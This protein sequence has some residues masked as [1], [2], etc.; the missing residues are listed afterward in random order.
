MDLGDVQH[1]Y[2]KR[3]D[4]NHA[5]AVR[6]LNVK[7]SNM[8]RVHAEKKA[9]IAE[10]R[11]RDMKRFRDGVAKLRGKVERTA[12]EM[13]AK[14]K[15]FEDYGDQLWELAR[16]YKRELENAFHGVGDI[17]WDGEVQ[18]GGDHKFEVFYYDPAWSS[19]SDNIWEGVARFNFGRRGIEV[20]I[21]VVSP[22]MRDET[23]AKVFPMGTPISKVVDWV[24]KAGKRAYGYLN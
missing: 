10:R 19:G 15:T 12:R 5:Y 17:N 2:L 3:L 4:S 22:D 13:V 9:K 16:D 8:N 6:K 18:K 7:L 21:M 14:G 20:D 24:G 23:E 1:E 11:V